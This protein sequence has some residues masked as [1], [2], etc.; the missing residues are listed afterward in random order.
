MSLLPHKTSKVVDIFSKLAM[1]AQQAPSVEFD[2][3]DG[4][5]LRIVL[6]TYMCITCSVDICASVPG[7]PHHI[8][9]HLLRV[10]AVD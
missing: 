7:V 1:S 3:T 6:A 9:Q 5:W 8:R 2:I 10:L 4:T